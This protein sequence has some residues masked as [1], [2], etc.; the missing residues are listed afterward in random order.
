MMFTWVR[1]FLSAPT[2]ED[3]PV[4]TCAARLLNIILQ[5]L[6]WLSLAVGVAVWVMIPVRARLGYFAF[7]STFVVLALGG[8]LLM[9]RGSVRLVGAL[10]VG[11]LFVM[12]TWVQAVF[13]GQR[14]PFCAAYMILV[15]IA[16]LSLG[17]RIGAIVAAVSIMTGLGLV[18]AESRGILPGP[19]IFV[20]PVIAWAT[21]SALLAL[22]AVLLYGST[23]S[24]NEALRQV[25]HSEHGLA[26]SNRELHREMAGRARAE[27]LLRKSDEKFSKAFR[28]S[29]DPF[30]ISTLREGRFVDVNESFLRFSG[31]CR[32]DVIGRNSLDISLWADP[33]DRSRF[34][35]MVRQ[36]GSVRDLEVAFRTKSQE[37][38]MVLLSSEVFE[39]GGEL[40]LLSAVKDITMRKRMEE[41]LLNLNQELERRVIERTSELRESEEKLRVQY[42]SIP[43]PTYTWQRE[44]EDF[45]LVDYNDAAL[46]ITQGQIAD[47]VG[48]KASEMYGDVPQILDELSRSFTER[49]TIEREMTYR[50]QTTGEERRL[51]VRY[52]FAPPDWVLVHTEDI[53]ERVRAQEAI[54]KHSAELEAVNRELADFAH[55]VSH[56]LKAPL[57][58]IS[59]LAHWISADYSDVLDKEGVDMLHLLV[60][61]TKHLHRLVEGILRYSSIG[62]DEEIRQR[63]GLN[64]LVHEVVE[65]LAPPGHIQ[66]IIEGP[67]PTVVGDR[68]RLKQVFQ[69]LL[70]NAFKF[71]DKSRGWVTVSCADEGTRWLFRVADN[72]PGIA[73]EHHDRIFR[74]FQTVSPRNGVE[75][76]GIG[77]AVVK[78][79]VEMWGGN[80]WLES[81]VGRGSTFC[82][83]YPK[84]GE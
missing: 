57:R 83:T 14:L 78:K 10:L 56:D 77:L 4:K 16:S 67:L 5:T 62:R 34:I 76:T 9:R 80:V 19:R 47:L 28:A 42:N 71:M 32:P 84:I 49:T 23:R 37:T 73:E 39:L 50:Y 68:T 64:S 31:Y 11:G 44:G 75:N 20:T 70:S 38:R 1:Q 74:M 6:L 7:L 3:E 30:I 25:Q 21:S 51:A 59:Q 79:I 45:V 22:A 35:E 8:R 72:G 26:K 82:F 17:E 13:V 36:Q 53:T 2:F 48:T 29:P 33:G 55:V 41:Q 63:V 27:E 60:S 65:M 66:V 52:A 46:A 69:N 18:Y 24:L 12:I 61:R 43:V 54:E 58:A 15:L 81:V 40:H